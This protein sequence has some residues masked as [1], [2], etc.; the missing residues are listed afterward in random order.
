MGMGVVLK[1]RTGGGG[2]LLKFRRP[3]KLKFQIFSEFI[4]YVNFQ[5]I[6]AIKLSI[7]IVKNCDTLMLLFKH[8]QVQIPTRGQLSGS[9][10]W[11]LF[12]FILNKIEDFYRK[13]PLHLNTVVQTPTSTNYQ[14]LN[15]PGINIK[16]YLDLSGGRSIS[17][18]IRTE[19]GHQ[20]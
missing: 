20:C 9:K 6:L 8:L 19:I 7:F 1:F 3:K 16:C 10:N 11:M 12:R 13:K 17:N 18:F 14:G 4:R 2:G 15:C 5:F